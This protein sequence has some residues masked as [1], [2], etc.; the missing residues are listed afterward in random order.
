[1]DDARAPSA[2]QAWFLPLHLAGHSLPAEIWKLVDDRKRFLEHATLCTACDE[3]TLDWR[4]CTDC[5]KPGAT[6]AAH[7]NDGLGRCHRCDAHLCSECSGECPDCRGHFC[8]GCTVTCDRCDFTVCRKAFMKRCVNCRKAFCPRDDRMVCCQRCHEWLCEDCVA[9]CDGCSKVFCASCV[10]EPWNCPCCL[11]YTSELSKA[12]STIA[13]EDG[14]HCA[15]CERRFGS[16]GLHECAGGRP[17]CRGLRKR[18]RADVAD[19]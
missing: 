12:C 5:S 3:W 16:D 8:Q 18:R 1:M 13:A 9:T 4:R 11:R 15:V 6:C 19:Q 10:S 17:V 7:E 2:A 14:T